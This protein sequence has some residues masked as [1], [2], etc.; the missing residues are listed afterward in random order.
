MTA[1]ALIPARGGSQGIPGKNLKPI[2]GRPLIHWTLRAAAGCPL[3]D[4]VYVSTDDPAIARVAALIP[5]VTVLDRDPATATA[6]ASTESVIHDALPKM[7]AFDD[8]VLIQATSPLLTAGDLADGFRKRKEAGATSALSV[9]RQKRFLWETVGNLAKPVN[10]DPLRRPRRQDFAGHLMENGAF[11]LTTRESWL[12]T[13]CRLGASTVAVEMPAESAV[14]IDE[15]EDWPVVETFLEQAKQHR[16]ANIKLLATDVDGTLT[17]GGMFYGPD[18]EALKKFN[19]R[20]AAGMLRLKKETGV[21]LGVITAEDS[22]S[23]HSRMR[24]LKIE[25]YAP[26]SKDKVAVLRRW[27]ADLGI[28][29]DQV[30]YIGDDFNDLPALRLCGYGA[31]PSDADPEVQA[32]ADRIFAQPGGGGCVRAFAD[33]IRSSRVH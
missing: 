25:R 3:I 21:E 7:G 26:G 12:A 29:L 33:L 15:P 24:K 19:T 14:E 17:D 4:R 20:D 16:L 13:G 10:Y 11:Y 18:G 22:P 28:G 27:C 2:A 23:V 1:V 9:V 32:A 6:T 31:C 8:L 30:A 5:G